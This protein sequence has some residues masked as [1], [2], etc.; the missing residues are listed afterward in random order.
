MGG[1]DLAGGRTGF[2]L[3]QHAVWRMTLERAGLGVRQLASERRLGN[4]Q[5]G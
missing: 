5:G 2:E 3:D 1:G 4:Q